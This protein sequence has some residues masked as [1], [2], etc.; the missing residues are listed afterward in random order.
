MNVEDYQAI[1][2]VT[3]EPTLVLA[4]LP[5]LALF[6]IAF[7]LLV[8]SYVITSMLMKRPKIKPAALE[9]WEFPQSDDGT[10]QAVFFGDGWATGPMVVWYGN[11][12][13]KKIKAKGGKGK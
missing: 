1:V 6:A 9:D 8:V 7:A 2:S 3:G 10:P 4:A 13:T 5:F 12:R 11:Y